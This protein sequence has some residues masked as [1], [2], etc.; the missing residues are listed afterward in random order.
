MPRLRWR[1]RMSRSYRKMIE[2]NQ[3]V[4]AC[5]KAWGARLL[6]VF[7]TVRAALSLKKAPCIVVSP[8]VGILTIISNSDSG[9]F[10]VELLKTWSQESLRP[11]PNTW[12]QKQVLYQPVPNPKLKQQLPSRL[13]PLRGKNLCGISPHFRVLIFYSRHQPRQTRCKK[14]SPVTMTTHLMKKFPPTC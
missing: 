14:L 10:G 8:C 9:F 11:H 5:R 4:S 1:F 2:T 6:N 3:V 13:S 12:S 7:E